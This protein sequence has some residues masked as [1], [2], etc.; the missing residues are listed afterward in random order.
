MNLF[1]VFITGYLGPIP[2][3]SPPRSPA[4]ALPDMVRALKKTTYCQQAICRETR[5]VIGRYF[6]DD[7]KYTGEPSIIQNA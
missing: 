6:S 7:D 5:I 1:Y 3:P 4:N 2:H